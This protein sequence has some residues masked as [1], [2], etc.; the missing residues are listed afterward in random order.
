M[1]HKASTIFQGQLLEEIFSSFVFARTSG[2][3]SFVKVNFRS[4]KIIQLRQGEQRHT[5]TFFAPF[6]VHFRDQ[7]YFFFSSLILSFFIHCGSWFGF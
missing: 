2:L 7:V 4:I 5:T 3:N 1:L 6:F